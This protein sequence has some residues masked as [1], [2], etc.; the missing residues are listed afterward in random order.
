MEHDKRAAV[1]NVDGILMAINHD[2]LDIDADTVPLLRKVMM[3]L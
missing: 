3:L 2:N 1:E